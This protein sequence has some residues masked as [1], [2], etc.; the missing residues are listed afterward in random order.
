MLNTDWLIDIL[1]PFLIV[2]V[3]AVV[4]TGCLLM[5][6]RPNESLNENENL[7]ENPPLREEPIRWI[8]GGDSS[9]SEDESP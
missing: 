7:P 1:V 9:G 3:A 2:G 6:R 5:L 8:L 4:V